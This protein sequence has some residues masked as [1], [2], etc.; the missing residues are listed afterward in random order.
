MW[1]AENESD[2][3]PL[4]KPKKKQAKVILSKNKSNLQ[5]P[6]ESGEEPSD[7]SNQL[8]VTPKELKVKSTNGLFNFFAPKA[9][10]LT[11]KETIIEEVLE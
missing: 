3:K 11:P 9:N 1:E 10:E 6:I 8:S 5:V 4:A 2:S 7:L